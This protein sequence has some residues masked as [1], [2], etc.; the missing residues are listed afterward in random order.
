METERLTA[1]TNGHPYFIQR[2]TFTH[3][4]ASIFG[5]LLFRPLEKAVIGL[6]TW[7]RRLQC[8][9]LNACL[10]T[11]GVLLVLILAASLL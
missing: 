9:Y 2:L 4:V 10:A 6:A 7:M 8:G 5:P 3:D 1:G 11:I